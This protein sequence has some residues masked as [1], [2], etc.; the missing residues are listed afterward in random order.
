MSMM[1]IARACARAVV[2]QLHVRMLLLSL[3]PFLASLALWGLG[4][5]WGMQ[6][7]IDILQRYFIEF[8]LFKSVG[9]TLNL[10]GLFALKT[11]IVP[12]LAMWMLLPIMVITSL[13][14]IALFAMP[15]INRHISLRYYPQLELRK[16]GNIIGSLLYAVGSFILFI[17][18]W[19]LS[20]PLLFFPPLHFI[21]QPLLWGWL[22]YRIMTYDALAAHADPEERKE[23]IREHRMSL[24]IIGVITGLLGA[25]PTLLWL[26]GVFSFVLFPLMAGLAIWLYV[27][28]FIFTGLWFQHYCLAALDQRRKK[29]RERERV[30]DADAATD[31]DTEVDQRIDPSVEI[32]ML[33]STEAL[34]K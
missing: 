7:F 33:A 29:M 31:S 9:E 5:W 10:F 27:L 21:T 1:A 15:A 19:L 14:A 13:L 24:L 17:I 26:G 4:M 20:L 34:M 32:T 11:L 18:L 3:W 12:L 30:I 25:A 2:S 22:S 6:K 16:G 28:V 23:L 8:D